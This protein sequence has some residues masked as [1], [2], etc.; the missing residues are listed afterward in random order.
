[1]DGMS[2]LEVGQVLGIGEDAAKMRTHRTLAQ[3]RTYLAPRV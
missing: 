2:F 3:L 1:M